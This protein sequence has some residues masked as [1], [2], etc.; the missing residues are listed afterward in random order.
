MRVVH[1][2]VVVRVDGRI[3]IHVEIG[4][5]DGGRRL[6]RTR[7][8]RLQCG[9]AVVRSSREIGQQR[10]SQLPC[11]PIEFGSWIWEPSFLT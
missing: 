10:C 11:L 9:V 3:L 6:V 5:R 2:Q 4:G 7:D 1:D 8:D